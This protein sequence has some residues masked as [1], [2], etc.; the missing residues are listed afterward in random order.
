VRFW[1]GTFEYNPTDFVESLDLETS[2]NESKVIMQA[3]VDII[4]ESESFSNCEQ[5]LKHSSTGFFEG[6]GIEN[7][8][9]YLLTLNEVCEKSVEVGNEELLEAMVPEFS[10]L[11]RKISE[12]WFSDEND[13]LSDNAFVELVKLS[14]FLDQHNEAAVRNMISLFFNILS[15]DSEY[16]ADRTEA[17]LPYIV[18]FC[19]SH[20]RLSEIEDMFTKLTSSRIESDF[21]INRVLKFALITLEKMH[22]SSHSQVA[23][24]ERI[25][26]LEI[27]VLNLGHSEASIRSLSLK[28]LCLYAILNNHRQLAYSQVPY[29]IEILKHDTSESK[30]DA[31]KCAFDI[32]LS[33]GFFIEN[34]D[35][36]TAN[37]LFQSLILIVKDIATVLQCIQCIQSSEDSQ[38]V[39]TFELELYKLALEGFGKLLIHNRLASETSHD[40]L[41][42][43]LSSFFELKYLFDD[44]QD[45]FP[46]FKI[47]FAAYV[48]VCDG[49]KKSLVSAFC[50]VAEHV[51]SLGGVD[52]EDLVGD[53]LQCIA[54]LVEQKT[55]FDS[56]N[57]EVGEPDLTQDIETRI[58]NQYAQLGI[59]NLLFIEFASFSIASRRNLTSAW[60]FATS[61]LGGMKKNSL[62]LAM[63]EKCLDD[64]ALSTS[65]TKALIEHSSTKS[66]TDVPELQQ[67]Q[68][69][70]QAIIESIQTN[71]CSKFFRAPMGKKIKNTRG[72]RKGD[73]VPVSTRSSYEDEQDSDPDSDPQ[74]PISSD[75]RRSARLSQHST[76]PKKTPQPVDDDDLS[77]EEESEQ[78]VSF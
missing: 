34:E 38:S 5:F 64:A 45:F 65:V 73:L 49:S 54:F 66:V 56:E 46:F 59:S 51:L 50:P 75:R 44:A 22:F 1:L 41:V 7:E 8:F 3:L 52:T 35:S 61:L 77:S 10:L 17:C 16:L 48:H 40:V 78:D 6:D 12:N 47:F 29:I 74:Q 71:Y 57:S 42:S 63:L 28:F 43:L 58:T 14:K 4:F 13:R 70:I 39:D 23:D 18:D 53:L 67:A 20:N 36:S 24:M 60:S 31:I 32:C 26:A 27:F 72:K 2:P 19:I 69:F 68:I 9:A 30:C 25:F 55:G 11:Y 76:L 33:F 37:D 62:C 15:S 21:M